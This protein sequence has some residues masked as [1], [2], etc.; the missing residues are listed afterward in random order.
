MDAETPDTAIYKTPSISRTI[1]TNGM[2]VS[3]FFERP[4]LLHTYEWDDNTQFFQTLQPWL[5][6]SHPAIAPKLRGFARLKADLVVEIRVNGSPFRFSQALV[7]YRPLF[8]RVKLT[9]DTTPMP[10]PFA[11]FSGG[12]LPEDGFQVKA[13]ANDPSG[14]SNATLMARS[15]RQSAYV[16]VA[17][18]RGVTMSLPFIHPHD[19]LIVS[20]LVSDTSSA[21]P[22]RTF[23]YQSLASMGTLTIESVANL[24][25]LQPPTAVGVSIDIF[26][27]AKNVT[28]W[29]SSGTASLNPQGDELVP[30]KVLSVMVP[31]ADLF[32]SAPVI[33]PLATVASLVMSTSSKVLQFFGYTPRPDISM[34]NRVVLSSSF[35]EPSVTAPRKVQSLSLDHNNAISIDPNLIGS[36]ADELAFRNFC[37]RSALTMR[38]YFGSSCTVGD[39]IAVLPVTPMQYTSTAIGGVSSPAM[40]RF[41]MPPYALA[42]MQH[43]HWRGT[44]VFDIRAVKS[45]FHRGRLRVS[46]EPDIAN[47]LLTES[48]VTLA[49]L[50]EGYTQMATWDL[51]ATDNMVFK[52]GFAAS[53]GRLTVPPLGRPSLGTSNETWITNTESNSGP[54]TY[55]NLTL[56]NY[57]D[58]V[59]GFLRISVLTRLQAPDA[60]YPVPLLIHTYYEDLELYDPTDN[61]PNLQAISSGYSTEGQPSLEDYN[62][63]TL[64]AAG[65]TVN[66]AVRQLVP[67]TLFPQGDEGTVHIFQPPSSEPEGIFEGEAL[68]SLRALLMREVYYDTLAFEV[69]RAYDLPDGSDTARV[70]SVYTPPAIITA[71]LPAYP[72]P[73]GTSGP[74]RSST[75]TLN[76]TTPGYKFQ[77]TDGVDR[78]YAPSLV[79]TPLF[80]IIRECFVGFRGGYNWKFTPLTANGSR[81]T[82]LMAS[83]RS[84]VGVG[85]TVG[86]YPR[87]GRISPYSTIGRVKIPNTDSGPSLEVQRWANITVADFNTGTTDT[88][89]S[90]ALRNVRNATKTKL[91][92]IRS[93]LNVS[94]GN[95]ASGTIS[96]LGSLDKTVGCKLPYFGRTRFLPGSS[97]GWCHSNSNAELA[98]GIR[99]TIVTEGADVNTRPSHWGSSMDPMQQLAFKCISGPARAYVSVAVSCCP[100]D[101]V[102]FGAFVNVPTLYLTASNPFSDT[103]SVDT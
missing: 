84:F 7:S 96:S 69:P 87:M 61:G 30:S 63:G 50:V 94:M 92:Y 43:R 82:A 38:A 31:V 56:D 88:L 103:S 73:Y 33:G 14:W 47:P 8:Q 71:L 24:R 51:D 16:D 54:I 27:Y 18:S 53:T 29:L 4:L 15:Q 86:S 32:K 65:D 95:F 17:S 58:Y 80:S 78:V 74:I 25:N 10:V 5:Y 77:G 68:G 34:S 35:N 39:A 13:L 89:F 45:Q 64:M 62:Y 85:D 37:S 26:V 40:R 21:T 20:N 70:A 101:D 2:D 6:F 11:E 44:M 100:S 23:F 97:T 93:L 48:H 3:H 41:Q 98:E 91:S 102:S 49:T 60:S 57:R 76:T 75:V 36:N 9:N 52:V 42:A 79:R 67:D 1:T 12:Y 99:L 66:L 28:A 72:H 90:A 46:W 55:G 59:N 81:I 19:A 83:R 22:D